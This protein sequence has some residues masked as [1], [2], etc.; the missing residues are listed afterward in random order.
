[1]SDVSDVVFVIKNISIFY[2][3]TLHVNFVFGKID[4]DCW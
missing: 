3:V 2:F 4:K 1:V